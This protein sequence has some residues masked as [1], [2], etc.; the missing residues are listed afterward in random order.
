MD[1]AERLFEKLPPGVEAVVIFNEGPPVVDLNFFYYSGLTSGL[2]EGSAMVLSRGGGNVVIVPRLEEETAR[3]NCLDKVL[4]FDNADRFLELLRSSLAGVSSAGAGYGALTHRRYNWLK[5]RLDSIEFTDISTDMNSMRLVKDAEEVARIWEASKIA[6]DVADRIPG[7]LFEGMTE[8]ELA[9]EINY[10]M[11]KTGSGNPA[12]QTITAFGAAS[13]EPHYLGG[14]TR[15][16]IN[17]FVLCDFGATSD[18][19]CSDITR[20]WFFGEPGDR[21]LKMYRTVREALELGM[22]SVGPGVPA[23]EVHYRVEKFIDGA[24]FKGRFIHPLGHSLGLA[25]H[26]G[27]RL[28]GASDLVLEPGMVFTVE[29]G[30]YLPDIGGVRLENDVVVTSGGRRNLTTASLDFFQVA[31]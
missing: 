9:A 29:P 11:Q 7:M 4:V 28:G 2:F 21:E 17:S 24:E 27:G 16:E 5:A 6:S 25:P 14:K 22:E 19:Y 1:R 3:K 12:F 8:K 20:T 13:A 30:I 26:D 15:L 23:S 18:L 31:P 10:A